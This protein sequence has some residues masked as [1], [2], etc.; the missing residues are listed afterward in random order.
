MGTANSSMDLATEP[1]VRFKVIL[2][3]P[4]CEFLII[5]C[6]LVNFISIA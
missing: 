5:F 6:F 1:L 4:N 3:S 2:E